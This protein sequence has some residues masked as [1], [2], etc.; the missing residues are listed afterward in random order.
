MST[1][2]TEQA[3]A[4]SAEHWGMVIARLVW[5]TCDERVVETKKT[6]GGPIL[7]AIITPEGVQGRSLY[8]VDFRAD[9]PTVNRLSLTPS[10]VT[11]FYE[12]QKRRSPHR[13]PQSAGLGSKT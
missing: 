1:P 12:R 5:E 2:L 7:S 10:Q 11:A 4:L 9:P 3:L 13:S 6:V 8:S